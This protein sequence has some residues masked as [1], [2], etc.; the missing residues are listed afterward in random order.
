[1]TLALTQSFIDSKGEYNNRLSIKYYLD[2]MHHGRFSTK[3]YSWDMGISTR[4]AL[5]IWRNSS[6][7]GTDSQHKVDSQ[8]ARDEKSGNGSLMRI[9]PIGV[10]LWKD[11]EVAR[12]VARAQ[13]KVTHPALACLEACDAFTELI[14]R[15][16]NRE[17]LCF[18]FLGYI[19]L[20]LAWAWSWSCLS[21]QMWFF[22][23]AVTATFAP[24]SIASLLQLR[25]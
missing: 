23:T 5:E 3:D 21:T 17:F 16:M 14:C 24:I 9:A 18:Y 2:W 15:A 11:P 8:L 22:R 13:S 4:Q 19:C 1:M 10:I 20:G 12:K 6:G 25:C 7:D